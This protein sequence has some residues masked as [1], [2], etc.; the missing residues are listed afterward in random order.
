MERGKNI[1]TSTAKHTTMSTSNAAYF[2]PGLFTP[3][4]SPYSPSGYYSP[5][6]PSVQ[7][8]QSAEAGVSAVE[9][10]Q[11]EE[12]KH[13]EEKPIKKPHQDVQA[14]SS[15]LS[16]RTGTKSSPPK[17]RYIFSTRDNGRAAKRVQMALATKNSNKESD[18][19][20]SSSLASP[21][22]SEA[23][24]EGGKKSKTPKAQETFEQIE[25][26]WAESAAKSPYV[27]A[28]LWL[29][30]PPKNKTQA[31]NW[32]VSM[33]KEIIKI[34]SDKYLDSMEVSVP[35][36]RRTVAQHVSGH[37]KEIS[38][39]S[40]KARGLFLEPWVALNFGAP[41]AG[42]PPEDRPD[43]NAELRDFHKENN[44]GPLRSLPTYP[45][46]ERKQRQ[47]M[48]MLKLPRPTRARTRAQAHAYAQEPTKL[49][50]QLPNNISDDYFLG[51]SPKQDSGSSS[52]LEDNGDAGES[53]QGQAE[54][55]IGSEPGVFIPR[56]ALYDKGE[57][58]ENGEDPDE[59]IWVPESEL[60]GT[61]GLSAAEDVGEV[62]MATE[63][64]KEASQETEESFRSSGA[65]LA[66]ESQRLTERLNR[67]YELYPPQAY[68]SAFT[69]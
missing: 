64:V 19:V 14:S 8:S 65:S 35:V 30:G 34:P 20:S 51:G 5:V 4:T 26:R 50:E 44:L 52:S 68:V 55:N 42:I 11:P 57:E 66:I 59:I 49:F 46:L 16:Y 47:R 28:P 18:A 12:N 45:R 36:L 39:R 40:E 3:P 62:D 53:Y 25:R 54:K 6:T 27:H 17:R 41:S 22:D 15:S 9:V 69:P 1:D 56:K 38:A 58:L 61:R 24:L 67:L 29:N 32:Y 2:R 7:H 48:G 43:F 37:G 63:A 23:D 33:T 21:R 60:H 31:K 10:I 13:I